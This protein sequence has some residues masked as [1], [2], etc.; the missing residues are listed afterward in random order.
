MIVIATVM[1]ACGGSDAVH[2]DASPDAS[3][4]AVTN[5]P[6]VVQGTI[7]GV[8]FVPRDAIWTTANASGFDFDKQ[9]TVVMVT[10]F[11]DAC[12]LQ[13][14]DTGVPNGRLLLFVLATTDATGA[15]SPIT[16]TGV[17]DEFRGQAPPSRQLVEPYYEID[18]AHCLGTTKHFGSAGS[19]TVTSVTDPQ[20]ATFDVTFD[21]GDHA[22]GSY[23]AT[24]CAAL[25]PNRT[26]LGGCPH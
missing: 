14:S 10:D 16:A 23:R 8:A 20:T 7:G 9:S 13:G 26:P 15:S 6:A 11:A 25:N 5:P 1:S 17:Y 24:A 19:V 12:A 22:T 4:D 2:P 3:P 21:S 18:D